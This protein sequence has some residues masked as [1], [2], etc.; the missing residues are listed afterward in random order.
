MTT[1]TA[2]SN[3]LVQVGA[4]PFAT[5]IQALRDNTVALGENDATVPVAIRL[6]M[7]LLGTLTTT[8]GASQTL[9]SLDLTPYRFLRLVFVAV[10]SGSPTGNLTVDTEV[11]AVITASSN[12]WRGIMDID[13]TDGTF[14]S[15]L[16][17]VGST[18]SAVSISY[19][20]DVS[21]TTAST[22]IVVAVS[23]GAFD[24][25]SVRVYGVR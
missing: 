3:T 23:T 22:S 9:S 13:L 7:Q 11:V 2:I 4:Y 16:A 5:T 8:S 1:Y 21:L 6:P 24:V 18:D 12:S 20:G 17:D 25:G 19:A 10:S 14:S 15:N